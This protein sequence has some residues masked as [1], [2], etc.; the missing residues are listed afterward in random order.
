M[1]REYMNTDKA[2]WKEPELTTLISEVGGG[3]NMQSKPARVLQYK[4]QSRTRADA[5]CRAATAY[6]WFKCICTR[7]LRRKYVLVLIDLS[8]L[9]TPQSDSISK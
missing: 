3:T 8:T 9:A 5:V 2:Q 1:K 6:I 4:A 7:N